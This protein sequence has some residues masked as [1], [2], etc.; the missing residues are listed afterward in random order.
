MKLEDIVATVEKLD[1]YRRYNKLDFYTPYEYQ[2]N[3]HHARGHGEFVSLPSDLKNE[4]LA[5]HRALMAANQVG[6]L[7]PYSSI[8]YTPSGPVT[9]GDIKEGD[10]VIGCDGK[11]HEVLQVFEQGVQPIYKVVFDDGSS[12]DCGLDHLWKYIHPKDRFEFNVSHGRKVSVSTYNQYRVGTLKQIIDIGGYIPNP[13]RRVVI[14]ICCPVQFYSDNILPI[15]PYVMGVLI[16]DGGLSGGSVNITSADQEI[17]YRCTAEIPSDCQIQIS[18]KY[19]YRI[20]GGKKYVR[21]TGIDGKLSHEKFIPDEYKYTSVENRVNLLRGLM[22]TDGSIYGNRTIEYCSTSKRLADDVRWLVQ[23]LGGKAYIKEKRP[24]YTHNGEKKSGRIAYQVRI[25]I[26][27]LNP[28]FIKRK[29][30]KYYEIRYR[31]ERILHSIEFSREEKAKCILVDSDEHTYLTDDFIVTHNTFC[32]AMETAIHL[33][34]LYPD[35]WDGHRFLKPVKVIVGSN[36]NETARDICQKE[37][38]GEPSED[39]NGTGAVPKSLIV[40]TNRKPGVTNAY[41]SVLVR[42]VSGGNSEVYFRAYE[43]GAKKFMGHR[44]EYAWLDEEPPPDIWSQVLRSQ[45]ATNGI[46]SITFTPEEGVTQVVRSFMSDIKPGQALI[47]ATWDDAPHMTPELREQKLAA[48]P[49]HERAMRARGEPLMGSGLVF[50]VSREIIECDPFPIPDHYPRINGVDFGFDHP[51]AC[52]FMAWDRESDTVYIYDGYKE[53][54]ALPA[55]HADAIRRR[56]DWIPIAWPK[57]GLQ[58][59][60][61]SGKSLADKYRNPPPEG[62]GLNFFHT[63]FTNPPSPGDVEGK[64]TFSVEVG[65]LEILEMMETGRFKVFKP[66]TPFW[67]E[68]G[69]YHRK[70]GKIV[71]FNDDFMSAV[72]YAVMFRR[73]AQVKIVKQPKIQQFRGLSNW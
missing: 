6:K 28:F 27:G 47:R 64:G 48:V 7:Q 43:Q 39:E 34:G 70:D 46:A 50:P 3:F 66:V 55:V 4:H 44:Y 53:S 32:G 40:K 14:P 21:M 73:N 61:G 54:K 56:G 62:Q 59:E 10:Y 29:A 18:G 5:I 35:W 41:D 36:T 25:K 13:S 9:M 38:F 1:D 57:D 19:Q 20:N 31:P 37:L 67:E 58:T 17:I 16:G 51:F 26:S 24:T 23:S 45:F 11:P 12:T 69:M 30:E 15:S 22:D 60:K 71:P 52:A 2:R 63:Y 68:L 42:H 49:E 8:I 65:I 33:T 72:R